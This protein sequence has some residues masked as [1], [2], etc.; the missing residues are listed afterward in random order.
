MDKELIAKLEDFSTELEHTTNLIKM[1][2]SMADNISCGNITDDEAKFIEFSRQFSSF[3]NG[4]V[5]IA[6][7]REKAFDALV[8]NIFQ[9]GAGVCRN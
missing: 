7:Q 4:L 6:E 9:G 3:L 5:I 2:E 8:K 1:A